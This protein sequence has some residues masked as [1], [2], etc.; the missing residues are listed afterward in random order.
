VWVGRKKKDLKA[1][2]PED[3]RDAWKRGK[4]RTEKECGF[5]RL[6]L[7][8]VVSDLQ[9]GRRGIEGAIAGASEGKERRLET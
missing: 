1:G 2:T 9:D 5:P 8:S 7:Q 6:Q 3:R 4:G